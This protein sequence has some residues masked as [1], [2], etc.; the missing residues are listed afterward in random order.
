[1][2]SESLLGPILRNLRSK[3][4][5]VVGG[6]DVDSVLGASIRVILSDAFS[7][8]DISN[9]RR[10]FPRVILGL[11]DP[12][13]RSRQDVSMLRAVDFAVTSSFEHSAS[14]LKYGT[15]TIDLI[16]RP[17]LPPPLT[18][19]NLNLP[20]KTPT[21]FYHGN[22][23]HLESFARLGL[24]ALERLS[25]EFD[26]IF[27]A[28]YPMSREGR[29]SKPRWLKRT[30]LVE[31]NWDKNRVWCRLSQSDVGIVPNLLSSS[32]MRPLLN[33]PLV[34]RRFLNKESLRRDDL[35]FRMKV[36]SNPGRI[37]PFGHFGIPV[38]ADFFPSSAIMIRHGVDGLLAL[39]QEQW[40]ENLKLLISDS[41]RRVSLGN[42]LRNRINENFNASDDVDRLVEFL[43]TH[44]LF[45]NARR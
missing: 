23:V 10:R 45:P 16:W 8:E 35:L 19:Q 11:A 20:H 17:D 31:E 37:I 4:L 24:T 38:V 3:G 34:G 22:R 7:I 27:E 2:V 5:S 44:F 14:A 21:V 40:F 41:A 32:S 18:S 9:I 29:W 12:K 26:F 42:S 6:T 1:M 15:P 13:I 39:N 25:E 36:T 30:K 43:R 33:A 28:H